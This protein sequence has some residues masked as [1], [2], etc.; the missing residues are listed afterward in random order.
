MTDQPKKPDRQS[1]MAR[2]IGSKS[3]R[4]LKAKRL[5]GQK[6]WFGLGMMGLVG[7]S[8]IL[9]T[10]IGLLVGIWIDSTTD[11]RYA[12]TLMLMVAGL[13]IGCLN[14]WYWL[15]KEAREIRKDEEDEE[16]EDS[17]TDKEEQDE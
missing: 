12:W 11:S 16:T 10:L 14:V 5:A 3:T 17:D 1:D 6:T 8:I 13:A 4:K 15:N 7:W 2:K 9:P